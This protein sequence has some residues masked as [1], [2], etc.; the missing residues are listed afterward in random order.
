MNQIFRIPTKG[1]YVTLHKQF[2]TIHILVK[3]N[4]VSSIS[5]FKLILNVSVFII[6][7]NRLI[8][9][10]L[11]ELFTH[12]YIMKYELMTFIPFG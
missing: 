1:N 4:C 9:A 5:S 6:L 12:F 10:Q 11:K 8:Y 2:I 7:M 3:L